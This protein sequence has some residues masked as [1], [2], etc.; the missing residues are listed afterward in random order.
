M[1]VALTWGYALNWRRQMAAVRLVPVRGTRSALG[2]VCV[3]YALYVAMLGTTLPTPLYPLYERGL[4][5]VRP[6]GRR[7]LRR[8]R[9]ARPARRGGAGHPGHGPPPARPC[10]GRRGRLHD[11]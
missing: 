7:G 10:A 6:R 8:I 5:C 2:V 3:A 9:G 11:V 4:G 1:D